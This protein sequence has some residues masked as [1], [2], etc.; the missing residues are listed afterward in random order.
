MLDFV[1]KYILLNMKNWKDMPK[2]ILQ[3]S[4]SQVLK[5]VKKHI[6]FQMNKNIESNAWGL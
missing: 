1:K 3:E 2:F 6:N 5:T 4:M